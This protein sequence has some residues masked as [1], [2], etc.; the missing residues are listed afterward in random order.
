[1]PMTPLP[2][3]RSRR[4]VS[5]WLWTGYWFALFVV[6]HIPLRGVALR[7]AP[8]SDKIIH[9]VAYCLLA[10]LGGRHLLA[11]RRSGSLAL[12][13]VWAAVY[14]AYATAD[15]WLQMFVG[16]TMSFGD[17]LADL[18][19]VAVATIV[20]ALRRRPAGI[21]EPEDSLPR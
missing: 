4:P 3:Q 9:F 10:W 20:L 11:T 16:R 12:L 21:S 17:W 18:L 14:A 8:Y 15:E 1:M 6:M 5:W 19:G 13:F 7:L 2:E